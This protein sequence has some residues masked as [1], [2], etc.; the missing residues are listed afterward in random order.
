MYQGDLMSVEQF[1]NWCYS[2]C[3]PLVREI[4]FQNGEVGLVGFGRATLI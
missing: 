3:V 1:H 4:T 2:S